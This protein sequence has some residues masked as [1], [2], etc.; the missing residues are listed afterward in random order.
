MST[1]NFENRPLPTKASDS[2]S[3]KKWHKPELLLRGL[4]KK[5]DTKK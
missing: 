5:K 1:G 4:I 3:W 2:K